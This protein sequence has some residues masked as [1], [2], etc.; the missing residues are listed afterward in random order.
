MGGAP[1][2]EK[3]SKCPHFNA[4]SKIYLIKKYVAANKFVWYLK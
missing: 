3:T 2:P 4:Q 1:S